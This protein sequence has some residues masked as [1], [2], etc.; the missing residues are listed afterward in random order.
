[1]IK[2]STFLLK[3]STFVRFYCK[4]WKYWLK[5]NTDGQKPVEGSQ[6]GEILKDCFAVLFAGG[7]ARNDN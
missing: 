6:L 7:Q 3:N 4:N 2:S 5:R 1:M